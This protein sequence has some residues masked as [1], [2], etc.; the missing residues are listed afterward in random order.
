MINEAK[1]KRVEDRKD[2]KK[3][4]LQKSKQSGE[5]Q[6]T[7]SQFIRSMRVE[8]ENTKPCNQCEYKAN[9]T[10]SLKVH[11]RSAHEKVAYTCNIC[12]TR[13]EA[14][15]QLKTH[16]KSVHEKVRKMMRW[17]IGKSLPKN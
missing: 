7:I 9:S 4:K 3:E 8:N 13:F 14:Y 15:E 5:V 17:T 11:V 10:D 6:M 1:K 2:D 16:K 12:E